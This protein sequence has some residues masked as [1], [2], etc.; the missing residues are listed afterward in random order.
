MKNQIFLYLI[1]L[2]LLYHFYP[3]SHVIEYIDLIKVV[4]DKEKTVFIRF[5]SSNRYDFGYWREIPMPFELFWM[6]VRAVVKNPEDCDIMSGE[7]PGRSWKR[8]K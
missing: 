5:N 4:D 1:L 3:K 7:R 8:S 6:R 2:I